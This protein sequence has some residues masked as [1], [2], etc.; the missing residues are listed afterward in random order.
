MRF[1]FSGVLSSFNVK[2]LLLLVLL[3]VLLI[4]MERQILKPLN[5]GDAVKVS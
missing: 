5:L 2:Q 4:L 3:T 1:T